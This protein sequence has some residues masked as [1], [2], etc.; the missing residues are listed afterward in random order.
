[1]FE[2]DPAAFRR[3][4]KVRKLTHREL[5]NRIG[6]TREA[7]TQWTKDRSP[8]IESLKKLEE[9]GLPVWR[10]FDTPPPLHPDEEAVIELWGRIP[11]SKREA[12]LDMARALARPDLRRK[13]DLPAHLDDRRRFKRRA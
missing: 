13:D 6:V 12:F 11:Q 4:M 1:M 10:L 2:W 5:A 7:V 3:E 8:G 9:A